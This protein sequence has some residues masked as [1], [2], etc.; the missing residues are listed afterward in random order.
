MVVF[1]QIIV[2]LELSVKEGQ[3]ITQDFLATAV[4]LEGWTKN[5]GAQKSDSFL[6]NDCW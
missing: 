3:D 4:I 2:F 5:Q 6:M 1:K